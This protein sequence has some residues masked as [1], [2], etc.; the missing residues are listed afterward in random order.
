MSDG[1]AF[2][3]SVVDET[4]G[5]CLDEFVW[6]GELYAM[7]EGMAFA[8]IERRLQRLLDGYLAGVPRV[9]EK[10]HYG[11]A[12][13]PRMRQDGVWLAPTPNVG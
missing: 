13:A 8:L 12:V 5:R 4:D 2:L 3:I 7:P 1:S 9:T 11:E 6:G 10:L